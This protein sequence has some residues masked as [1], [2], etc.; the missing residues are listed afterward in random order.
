MDAVPSPSLSAE[1]PVAE[2]ETPL[3]SERRRLREFLA[4]QERR[5]TCAF[6][7]CCARRS[8]DSTANCTS[9]TR[10]SPSCASS[11]SNSP[12]GS[13]RF[14][15]RQGELG[16]AES[17]LQH[18]LVAARASAAMSAGGAFLGAVELGGGERPHPRGAGIGNPGR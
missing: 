10:R 17:R 11:G 9:A 3:H 5:F 15:Q 4:V 8:N 13:K 18:Q 7:P 6:R 1:S 12:S 14:S 16:A 2:P